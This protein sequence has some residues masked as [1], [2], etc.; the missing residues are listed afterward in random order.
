MAGSSRG[1]TEWADIVEA[2][3]RDTNVQA[4][5]HKAVDGGHSS[6][7]EAL[8]LDFLTEYASGVLF[9]Q[10]RL[11]GSVSADLCNKRLVAAENS[12][13]QACSFAPEASG[14]VAR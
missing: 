8:R 11:R 10:V 7:H 12:D 6:R 5:S 14:G 1:R 9:G 4:V 2:A 13:H 3:T